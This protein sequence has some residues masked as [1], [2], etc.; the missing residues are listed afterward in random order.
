MGKLLKDLL[1]LLVTEEGD[2][3]VLVA[4]YPVHDGEGNEHASGGHWVD[5]A[6]L[7]GVDA[8]ADDAA[9]EAEAASDDF[10]G[11]EL[12]EVGELVELAKDEA[13]DGAKDRRADEGPVSAHG[14]A[15]LLGGGA[16]AGNF[17]SR[18]DGVDGGLPDHLAEELF[19]IGEVEVDGPFGDPGAISYVLEPG[20]GEPAF[21][22]NLE[23]GLDD[24]L[25]P[26]VGLSSP[27][28]CS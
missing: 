13:V 7:T 17:L 22:E 18:L 23:R 26:V 9:Q 28:W 6:E 27:F 3:S 21:P 15:E 8:P 14:S 1:L 25:R 12:G 11:V 2:A 19:L 24:L 4:P 5:V 10:V 16:L 20:V